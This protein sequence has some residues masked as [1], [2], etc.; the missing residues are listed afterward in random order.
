MYL[1]LI[2]PVI[3]ISIAVFA[4]VLL[5]PILLFTAAA[6]LIE[7]GR[8]ILFVHERTGRGGEG[9]QIFKF[10]SMGKESAIIES[11]QAKTLR[12]TRVGAVIRRLNVDELPQFFNVLRQ[13][14]SIVGPRPGLPTQADL[15]EFR[16]ANGAIDLLPGITGLAQV[17]SFDDMTTEEKAAFDGDYWE[18]VSMMT[19]IKVIL[20]TFLYFLKPPPTY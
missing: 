13:D 12:V 15:H 20:F 6:I 14:M 11:A 9:F 3:D 2:K 4:L 7:D 16:R 19:D 1:R 5:S 8:P 10:R 17:N 18:S